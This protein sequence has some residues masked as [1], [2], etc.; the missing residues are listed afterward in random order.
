LR[1][2]FQSLVLECLSLGLSLGLETLSLGFGVGISAS[3]QNLS[4]VFILQCIVT[5]PAV[6][7]Y[8]SYICMFQCRLLHTTTELC[9]W[10]RRS[11]F[12]V[13]E[14]LRKVSFGGIMRHCH[15]REG[16]P[17]LRTCTLMDVCTTVLTRE[18]RWI[19][20]IPTRW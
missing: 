10:G 8:I 9:T 7:F 14:N 1:F 3:Q 6:L 4:T 2:S 12:L 15:Q 19:R 5:R 17:F 16:H 20:T 13:L 11:S 18:C